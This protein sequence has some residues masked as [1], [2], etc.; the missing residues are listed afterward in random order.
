MIPSQPPSRV[1]FLTTSNDDVP[2]LMAVGYRAH[3]VLVWNALDLRIMGICEPGIEN[4][5]IDAMV[6]NPNPDIPALVVS[7]Q[8]GSL[9][10]FDYL[11]MELQSLKP[12]GYAHSLACSSNGRSLVTGSSQGL[13]EI[14]DFERENNGLITL[15]PIYRTNHPLDLTI[16]SITFSA[17]GLRFLDVRGQQGRVWAPAALVRKS[18]GDVESSV[19]DSAEGDASSLLPPKSTGVVHCLGDPA[20]T[21]P[22]R[23][24][25]DGRY[26]VAG[27]SSG[28]V[29]LFSTIDASLVAVLYQHARGASVVNITLGEAR[30]MV[31]SADDSGRI[32]VAELSVPASKVSEMAKPQRARFIVDRRF[33][34]AVARM[35]VNTSVDRLLVCGRYVDELWEIPSGK[36]LV[37]R[38]HP[39]LS[40]ATGGLAAQAVPPQPSASTA[41]VSSVSSGRVDSGALLATA[42]PHSAFRHPATDDWFVLV[43]GDIVRIY[44]WSDFTEQT[45]PKGIRLERLSARDD[46]VSQSTGDP[47]SGINWTTATVS[48]HVGPAFVTELIRP[49]ASASPRLYLWLATEFN[50]SSGELVARPAAEPNLEAI[51]PAVLEVLGMVSPSTLVFLDANLWVCTTELQSVLMAPV[52]PQPS[53]LPSPSRAIVGDFQPLGSPRTSSSRPLPP[54]RQSTFSIGSTTSPAP[55]VHARRHFFVLSEWQ[56]AGTGGRLKCTLA[57]SAMTPQDGIS[58][59]A[60]PGG[61]RS[62]DVVVAT[63]HHLVVV[64]GGFDFY[65]NVSASQ[66]PFTNGRHVLRLADGTGNQTAGFSM[67]LGGGQYVWNVVSGSMHRRLLNR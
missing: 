25:M 36:V 22:L 17:D 40:S 39:E 10:V 65:E 64:K 1:A 28:E 62:R 44:A 43:T 2:M 14:F 38:P 8:D 50:P 9:C 67:A 35:L 18:A 63:G 13:I 29:A 61:G 30:N 58:R 55:I 27:N 49:S 26:V 7:Y 46:L 20:I 11:E 5:G 59:G 3:P 54:S 32:L 41:S 45:S 47:E 57:T 15:V 52:S 6:F 53:I 19:V 48:Y 51:G 4:N 66:G 33:G 34:T 31:I 42:H 24:T 60:S 21:S 23:A 16:R 12:D 37:D 56:T